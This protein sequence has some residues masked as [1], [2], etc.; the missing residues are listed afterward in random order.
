MSSLSDEVGKEKITTAELTK[1]LDNIL[2]EGVGEGIRVGREEDPGEVETATSTDPL[3]LL[4]LR[5]QREVLE[6][7]ELGGRGR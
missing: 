2:G 7:C 5:P 6:V 4:G 3:V 1:K